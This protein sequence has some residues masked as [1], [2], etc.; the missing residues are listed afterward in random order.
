MA[1]AVLWYILDSGYG[2]SS[3]PPSQGKIRETGTDTRITVSLGQ[4]AL[5]AQQS[6]IM[7]QLA[8]QRDV[9][10]FQMVLPRSVGV[11]DPANPGHP[12]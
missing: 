3:C 10:N 5:L 12:H 1:R 7:D 9:R 8:C 6:G 2:M 4:L 11:L